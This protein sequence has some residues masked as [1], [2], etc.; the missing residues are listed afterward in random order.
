MQAIAIEI[1]KPF[2]GFPPSIM[3]NIFQVNTNNSYSLRLGNELY[4]RNPKTVKYETKTI[5][6]LPPKIWYLIPEIIKK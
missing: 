4:C 5:S 6:H 3:K 1:Y 2:H